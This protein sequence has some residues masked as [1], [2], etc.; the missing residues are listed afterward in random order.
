ML[1]SSHV[2][3]RKYAFSSFFLVFLLVGVFGA[4]KLVA[5]EGD[6]PVLFQVEAFQLI[7]QDGQPFHSA[8]LFGKVWV[9]SFLFTSCADVCPLLAAQLSNLRKR[10]SA[11]RD[12][13]RVVSITV[14][15]Q[16]DQPARLREFAE[17]FGWDPSWILLTGPPAEVERVLTKAFFQPLPQ[18]QNKDGKTDIL[19]GT[20]VLLFDKQG[21]CR[22]LYALEGDGM[23]KIVNDLEGLM[24]E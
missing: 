22:G 24:N 20:G 21:R 12:R 3:L 16:N 2:G 4:W 17:R 13:F 6:L 14:D 15:P 9:A 10:M 7:D 11:H 1:S 23:E 8:S 5:N 18:R 19:H